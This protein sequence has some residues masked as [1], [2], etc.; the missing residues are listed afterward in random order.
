M[1]LALERLPATAAIPAKGF[2][3][4]VGI[5]FVIQD[6]SLRLID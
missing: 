2:P 4:P 3:R 1:K 6:A 5:L